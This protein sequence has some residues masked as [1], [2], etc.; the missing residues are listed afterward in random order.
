MTAMAHNGLD[1]DVLIIGSGVGGSAVA[2]Q[3]ADSGASVWVLE[4][5]PVLPREA[6]NWD[7]E[8]VFA[9]RRYQ[10]DEV[11][12]ASG[13]A[14]RPGMFYFVGGHTKFYGT[15]MLRFRQRDFEAV[16]H[17]EGI[18]PAW[19]LR[20]ADL[21]PWYALAEQRFGVRGQGGTDPTEP[22]RSTA[23]AHP[24]VPHEP[25]LSRI[26]QRLRAQGLRPFPMPCAID[27]GPG[28]HCRRC[29]NCDA[30]PCMVG[31]KG[32]AE[33]CLLRPALAHRNV[34]LHTG[35][36]VQRLLTDAGGR[37]VVAAEVVDRGVARRITA[38]LFVLSAGAINS[39]ALLL[40][41]ANARHP[42]GLANGSDVVGRHYMTHNTTAL[43]AWHPFRR[44]RTRFPKTLALHDFYFGDGAGG[45]PLGSLQLLGKIR[46]PMLRAALPGTPRWLRSAL[47]ERSVDWYAQ[48]EDLP[49]P[50]SRV[51]LRA[52][53]AI[54][55]HWHRTNLRAHQRWVA[56]CAQILRGTG[57]PLVLSRGFGTEVVSHQCGTV[58]LGSDPATSALDPQCKAWE[59]DNLYV[60]DAG[61]FP[62]SAAV[63]PALTVA[64][65]AL[66]VGSHLRHHLQELLP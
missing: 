54:D 13:R 55:L 6:Q 24:P 20:Y 43:M 3:L 65:Q 27:L 21:E 42:R 2:L 17:E 63:N 39:A 16:E 11:W 18:S 29:A 56:R 15:A 48:S 41:S 5:G 31:A 37:R 53:G 49:H 52:D 40:R 22:P 23:Y 50:S 25:L 26:E 62:S 36:R 4:R 59:L 61:F 32:D 8:A 9:E 64:A 33:T 47:A 19:P 66:R 51:T 46:E 28:G 44:N 10:T 30:V 14:F 34:R 60:V 7:I 35:V 57:Y 45:P 1:C 38:G 12:Y 58:R